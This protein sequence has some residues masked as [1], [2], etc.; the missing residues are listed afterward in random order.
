MSVRVASLHCYPLKSGGG[1]DLESAQLTSAGIAQDRCWMVISPTGRF[2]TQREL[3]RLALIR[4]QL[5]AE[6]LRL[7]APAMDALDI[8]LQ[9]EGARLPVTI[10]NDRCVG[11]DEGAA[12]ARW[13]GQVLGQE[14]RLVRFDP[15]QRRLSAQR[16]TGRIEAENRFSDGFPLLVIGQESLADLNRRLHR[17]LPMNRFRPNIVLEG[18]DPYAEDHIDELYDDTVRLRLVKACT[19]CRI[20]TTNQDTGEVEGDQPLRV[21]KMY[22]LDTELRG[23]IFGQNAVIVAGIGA[24]LRPGQP[25]Q[26]KW[27]VARPGEQRLAVH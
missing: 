26:V 15:E 16:W 25:L 1:I 9:S 13:L 17:P 11:R 8:A 14:C 3:P 22:R 27:K 19:R 12:A 4:P 18:L 21:L 23:V 6:R 20:T 5:S 2:L 10:W 7:L 24:T